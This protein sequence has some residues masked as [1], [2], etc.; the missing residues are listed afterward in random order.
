MSGEPDYSKST[1]S[2]SPRVA[3]LVLNWNG[4]TDTIECLNSLSEISYPNFALIVVD[5]GSTDASVTQISEHFR[6]RLGFVSRALGSPDWRPL[7]SQTAVSVVLSGYSNIS[8]SPIV[9]LSNESN[10]GYA[11]G[12]NVGIEFATK[13]L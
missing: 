9:L 5:N 3:I 12:N 11:G 1:A 7:S 2:S 10:L 13:V 8:H 6:V 4:W